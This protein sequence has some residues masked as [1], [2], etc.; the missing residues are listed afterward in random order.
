MV[1]LTGV[2]DCANASLGSARGIAIR[3]RRLANFFMRPLLG[4]WVS[5]RKGDERK[6]R[7]L[8]G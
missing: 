1:M 5:R 8:P 4:T 6:T 3:T 7:E 2:A